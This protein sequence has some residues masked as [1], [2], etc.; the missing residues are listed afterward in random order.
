MVGL[1]FIMTYFEVLCAW[2]KKLIY[3][4]LYSTLVHLD[5]LLLY[6][7]IPSVTPLTAAGLGGGATGGLFPCLVCYPGTNNYSLV[8]LPIDSPAANNAAS[9]TTTANLTQ[10]ASV[11]ATPTSVATVTSP[12]ALSPPLT[13]SGDIS[14]SVMGNNPLLPSNLSAAI[15]Q[16]YLQLL[17]LQQ[18]QQSQ[19]NSN[20]S[21]SSSSSLLSSGV[22][23]SLVSNTNDILTQTITT[24]TS[25]MTTTPSHNSGQ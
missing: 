4:P 17:Q 11:T 21:S 19:A 22:H 25:Q 1:W 2:T 14:P 16:S 10:P 6:R 23:N 12:S 7:S 13:T 24:N 18:L 3:L 9:T 15:T 8:W 20:S 5:Y